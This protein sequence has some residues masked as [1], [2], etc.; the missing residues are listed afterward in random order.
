M[1]GEPKDEPNEGAWLAPNPPL[2]GEL[3]TN[4]EGAADGAVS[5]TERMETINVRGIDV[6]GF[7]QASY[8]CFFFFLPLRANTD[9]KMRQQRVLLLQS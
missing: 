3:N 7:K 4:G 2:G 6:E 5:E 8:S 9:L 1:K